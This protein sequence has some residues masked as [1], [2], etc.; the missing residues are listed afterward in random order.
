VISDSR[1]LKALGTENIWG[2][3]LFADAMLGNAALKYLLGKTLPC[4]RQI[5]R[6]AVGTREAAA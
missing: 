3:K 5:T 4:R 2:K 1:E 6:R